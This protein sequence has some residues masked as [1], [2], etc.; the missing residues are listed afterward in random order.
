MCKEIVF[1]HEA[2]VTG[3]VSNSCGMEL[4]TFN[5]NKTTIKDVVAM[6]GVFLHPVYKPDDLYIYALR[7]AQQQY[8]EYSE[9][10]I[11][12]Y[13]NHVVSLNYPEFID[14]MDFDGKEKFEEMKKDFEPWYVEA[15]KEC[16]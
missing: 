7:G 15:I 14:P 5:V 12:K 4:L 2:F 9:I 16:K 1:G 13:I 11:N 8:D 10:L 3:E 6:G